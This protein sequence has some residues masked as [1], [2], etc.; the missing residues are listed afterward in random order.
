MIT[1]IKLHFVIFSFNNNVLVKGAARR[2]V[3]SETVLL[4]SG[5]QNFRFQLSYNSSML[6]IWTTTPLVL[7]GIEEAQLTPQAVVASRSGMYSALC[8][9]LHLSI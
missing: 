4:I 1:K 8:P 5:L 7:A 2:M 6:N 3:I 9:N